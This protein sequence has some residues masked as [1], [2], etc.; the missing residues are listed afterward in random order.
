MG[1]IQMMKVRAADGGALAALMSE[2]HAVEA[3]VAPGYEGSRLLAD[4]DDPGRYTIVVYFSSFE[5]AEQNNDRPETQEWA[6][7]LGALIDGEPE[8]ANFDEMHRVG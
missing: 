7:K 5:E 2:W 1:F 4:R 8:F 3:G 6:T